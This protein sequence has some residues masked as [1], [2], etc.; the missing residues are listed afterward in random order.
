MGVR[1]LKVGLTLAEPAERGVGVGRAIGLDGEVEAR[2]AETPLRVICLP[3]V[4]RSRGK[5]EVVCP[6]VIE[7]TADRVGE[8][9]M[10]PPR[11]R[12]MTA[13]ST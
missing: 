3:P 5:P 7:L 13:C 11:R 8:V 4:P 6:A 10:E 1:E 9:D 12:G 2:G